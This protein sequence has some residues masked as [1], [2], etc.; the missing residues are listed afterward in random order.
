MAVFLHKKGFSVEIKKA[1]VVFDFHT[2]LYT[3]GG[4]LLA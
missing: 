2:R 1:D 3:G 4:V